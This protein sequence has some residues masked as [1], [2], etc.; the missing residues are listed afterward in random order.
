MKTTNTPYKI[1]YHIFTDRRDE[2][3]ENYKEAKAIYDRWVAEFDCARLYK[4][5]YAIKEE[6]EYGDGEEDCILSYGAFPI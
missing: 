3:T 6:F 2:W 1:V 5:I 4:D